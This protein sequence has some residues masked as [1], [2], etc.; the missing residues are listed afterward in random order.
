[1][2]LRMALCVLASLFV[3]SACGSA[4]PAAG[5]HPAARHHQ[6]TPEA[7]ATSGSQDAVPFAAP[8]GPVMTPGIPVS[9]TTVNGC[10][11]TEING[12]TGPF[13]MCLGGPPHFSCCSGGYMASSGIVAGMVL[14]IKGAVPMEPATG[15]PQSTAVLILDPAGK[16]TAIP[17]A[18]DGGFDENVTF[19]GAGAY[20]LGVLYQGAPADLIRFGVGWKYNVLS[21]QTLQDLFPGQRPWPAYDT[22]L[23]APTGTP[24]SW[25]LEVESSGGTPQPG[26]RLTPEGLTAN[27]SGV[28]NLAAPT[29]SDY[30][31]PNEVATGL[32]VQY[33]SDIRPQGALLTGFPA[34]NA[35]PVP[36]APFSIQE[37]GQTYYDVKD[38]F[39]QVLSAF[40]AGGP[41][42]PPGYSFDAQGGVLQLLDAN[43]YALSRVLTASGALQTGSVTGDSGDVTWTTVGKV[44]PMVQGD[45]V[46]L[47]LGDMTALAKAVA[48]AAPDGQGGMLFSDSWIP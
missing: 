20:Q 39:W 26:A 34:Q 28:L 10:N 12:A 38:F 37:T 45:R 43:R 32:Y 4:S 33:Y 16:S 17:V 14:D 35:G 8:S 11:P 24:A 15:K 30:G 27:S 42:M 9:D 31:P 41:G 3:L 36:E 13:G 21:G 47:T 25:T 44:S 5:P 46:Y 6:A 1:M 29:E 7:P 48:W 19:Q 23:A 22:V 40:R 2:R 18:P